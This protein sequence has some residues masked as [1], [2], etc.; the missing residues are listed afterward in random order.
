ML[1]DGQV[2]RMMFS[3]QWAATV[4]KEALV[5]PEADATN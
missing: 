3:P 4:T 1:A 5:V 2:E